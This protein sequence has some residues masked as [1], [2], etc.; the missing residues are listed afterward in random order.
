MTVA[1]AGCQANDKKTRYDLLFCP[2]HHFLPPQWW[3]VKPRRMWTL[4]GRKASPT[5]RSEGSLPSSSSSSRVNSSSGNHLSSNSSNSNSSSN[6][7]NH[8]G[9]SSSSL[10]P[11]FHNASSH[12]SSSSPRDQSGNFLSCF[13]S[14]DEMCNLSGF[15]SEFLLTTKTM[16]SLILKCSMRYNLLLSFRANLNK[17][18]CLTLFWI[19]P[20]S[21]CSPNCGKFCSDRLRAKPAGFL[22]Q[23]HHLPQDHPPVHAAGRRLW[24]V[25]RNRGSVDLRTPVWGRELF[26]QA[27]ITRT[28]LH[29][30]LRAKHQRSPVLHHHC[31]DSLAGRQACGI[32]TRWRPGEL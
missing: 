6:S 20:N 1:L 10:K 23:G 12:S 5:T 18:C 31:Q 29:G 15:N 13:W 24:E 21:G 14:F 32:R 26:D 28:P 7:S 27:R 25:W 4:W 2:S 19:L 16:E 3:L 9:N 30:Q 22:L 8:S 17:P 11:R